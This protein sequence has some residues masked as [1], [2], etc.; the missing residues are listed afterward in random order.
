MRCPQSGEGEGA[1]EG[2]GCC[3]SVPCDGVVST[4]W[5]DDVIVHV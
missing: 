4:A 3:A 5:G 1:G 2:G